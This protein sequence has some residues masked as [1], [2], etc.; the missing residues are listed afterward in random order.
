MTNEEIIEQMNQLGA[1]AVTTYMDLARADEREKLESQIADLKSEIE[2]L[3]NA[4]E[5]RK[6]IRG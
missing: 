6:Y 1:A 5:A 3:K 4:L 2:R